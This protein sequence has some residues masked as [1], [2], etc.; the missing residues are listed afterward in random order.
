LGYETDR[1]DGVVLIA[2]VVPACG[3]IWRDRVDSREETWRV[4]SSPVVA[5]ASPVGAVV[6][7]KE[8]MGLW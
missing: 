8:H 1:V 4:H 3:L 2:V 5:V 6:G 7:E